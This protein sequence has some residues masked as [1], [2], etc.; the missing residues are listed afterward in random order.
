MNW[1]NKSEGNSRNRGD[2]IKQNKKNLTPGC[3]KNNI[4]IPAFLLLHPDSCLIK[5]TTFLLHPD[6]CMIFEEF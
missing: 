3:I 1:S 6:S 4:L 5:I 2:M